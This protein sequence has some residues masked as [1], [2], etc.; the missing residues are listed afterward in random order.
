MAAAF[1]YIYMCVC[2]YSLNVVAYNRPRRSTVR[3]LIHR[4]SKRGGGG[5]GNKR[6]LRYTNGW[7][8]NANTSIPGSLLFSPSKNSPNRLLFHYIHHWFLPCALYSLPIYIFFSFLLL[9]VEKI[10][11][12]ILRRGR[13]SCPPRPYRA[14]AINIYAIINAIVIYIYR[15]HL[16]H[17][18]LGDT[19]LINL[20]L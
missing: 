6:W 3:A 5:R 8:S 18:P 10:N 9:R 16:F 11:V 2:I 17:V 13:L 4:G 1:I 7:A 20:G 15:S 14:R 12:Y 19:A